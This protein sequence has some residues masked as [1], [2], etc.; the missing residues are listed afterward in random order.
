MQRVSLLVSGWFILIPLFSQP[1]DSDKIQLLVNK[2]FPEVCE[3]MQCPH[4]PPPQV[5]LMQKDELVSYLKELLL[6]DNPDHDLQKRSESL[7]TLGLLPEKFDLEQALI[8]LVGQVA[9]GLYDYRTKKVFWLESLVPEEKRNINDQMILAHELTHAFQDRR[10][11]FKNRWKALRENIDKEYAFR[12]LIEGM[13]S[14]IMIAYASHVAIGQVPDLK[15]F[16]RSSFYQGNPPYT[17]GNDYIREY[18]ISAYAEGGAFVQAWIGEH[19]GRSLS[20]LFDRP[21]VTSE[22]VLHYEKYR[23]MDLP[24]KF[25][26]TCLSKI[27]PSGWRVFYQN[28]LGEFDLWQL[29]LANEKTREQAPVLA[30]GWDGFQFICWET[31]RGNK[32]LAGISEWDSSED[33]LE[34]TEAYTALLNDKYGE[35]AVVVHP[36]PRTM[37]F[38][39]GLHGSPQRTEILN[40]L[41]ELSDQILE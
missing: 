33:A 27:V 29:F 12:G 16:W 7:S 26:F 19:P 5:E 10:L 1:D 40:A 4:E 20:L 8:E 34:F 18:L 9:G 6:E 38:V 2:I 14:L 28:T 24:E 13:A 22:Q 25:D 15:N 41:S 23:E 35:Q 3:L 39:I 32:V 21:P 37:G 30:S 17:S 31:S 11:D 36:S